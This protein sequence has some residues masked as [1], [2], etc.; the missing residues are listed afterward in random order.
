V[1][2]VEAGRF[3]GSTLVPVL[4]SIAPTSSPA[5]PPADVKLVASGSGFS[6]DAC[7]AFG[8]WPDGTPRFER[9]VHELDGTL[10]LEITA[11]LFPGVDPA[12]PVRVGNHPPSG[13]VTD[14]IMFAFT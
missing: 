3:P 14:A 9:T 10:S 12:I 13:P 11:G 8:T 1:T 5:G 2:S 7:I 6:A 4:A